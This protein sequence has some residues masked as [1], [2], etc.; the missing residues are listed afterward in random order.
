[1]LN[2]VQSTQSSSVGIGN[3]PFTLEKEAGEESLASRLCGLL[4]GVVTM[5]P[6]LQPKA[7]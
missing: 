3:V 2:I 7:K 5:D 4:S 6:R 1:M